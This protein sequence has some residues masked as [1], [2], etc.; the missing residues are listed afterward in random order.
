MHGASGPEA[1]GHHCQL[2]WGGQNIALAN[3]GIHRVAQKPT[4]IEGL[5]LPAPGGGHAAADGAKR[6]IVMFAQTKPS[7]HGRN[8]IDPNFLTNG[9][10][11]HI[12]ALDDAVG[13]I[14]HAM[15]LP[16]P[17]VKPIVRNLKM[18]RAKNCIIR[19]EHPIFECCQCRHHFERGGWG[20]SSLY[21]LR[22]KGAKDIIAQT[23]VIVIRNT[24]HKKIWIKAWA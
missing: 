15:A 19:A 11:K 3:R 22:A 21:G 10:E 1:G 12:A 20:I 5:L 18:T 13:H 7:C 9:I 23:V 6:Q 8:F 16:F 17:A 14:H 4:F 24:S 2:K